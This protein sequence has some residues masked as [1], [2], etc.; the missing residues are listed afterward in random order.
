M[1]GDEKDTQLGKVCVE[2]EQRLHTTAELQC[3]EMHPLHITEPDSL[4]QTKIQPLNATAEVEGTQE[5]NT[6]TNLQC[7]QNDEVVLQ[8]H[9]A[10]VQRLPLLSEGLPQ[11][12]TNSE[13]IMNTFQEPENYD[14][15]LVSS[16]S[17]GDLE[18]HSNSRFRTI[19]VS[20]I[21]SLSE[22]EELVDL[23]RLEDE[24]EVDDWFD[25]EI[26][27]QEQN[28]LDYMRHHG[29]ILPDFL[30]RRRLSECREVEEE[31]EEE[32][33]QNYKPP[34]LPPITTTTS[35]S[36][37]A[38]TLSGSSS[39]STT[40]HHESGGS[41]GDSL[42]GCADK[43]VPVP[44]SSPS[45]KSDSGMLFR[46][47]SP[48]PFMSPHLDK[49]FIDRSLIEMKS[50]ASSTST[51]DYDSTEDIWVKRTESERDVRR[52]QVVSMSICFFIMNLL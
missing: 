32:E 50:Q 51:L 30:E 15:Q 21:G 2:E 33:E 24:V 27:E 13:G 49:R 48:V 42:V 19:T 25:D 5:C 38:S 12:I 4:T 47:R 39:S 16:E 7:K 35:A 20:T 6:T 43:L 46:D 52:R 8:H 31:E 23:C 10:E 11:T 36:T 18:T 34:P 14:S 17:E 28:F 44:P 9:S 3:P 29:A 22:L 26:T 1:N 45:A 37:T 40:K 41:S